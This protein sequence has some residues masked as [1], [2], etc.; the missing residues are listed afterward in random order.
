MAERNQAGST[1]ASVA[2]DEPT[3]TSSSPLTTLAES[4]HSQD[5]PDLPPHLRAS[6]TKVPVT[7]GIQASTYSSRPGSESE[8][9][10]SPSYFTRKPGSHE[11]PVSDGLPS[12]SPSEMS[13]PTNLVKGATSHHEVLRRMSIST[14]GRRESIED[15]RAAAP[16]L[17]LSG[18]IISVTSTT[19]HSLKYHKSGNWELGY[20]RGQSA[21]FDSFSYLSSDDTPWNHS[22][23]AWTGEIESS[24]QS[25]SA[26][27]VLSD[28][29]S[30]IPALSHLSAP[31]PLDGEAPPTPPEVDGLWIPREHQLRLE[32]LL[33]HNKRI[34]TIPVWLTDDNEAGDEGITLNDQA[35][36]KRY[37]EHTIYPLFH[38]KQHEPNDGRAERVEWADYFRANLKFANKIIEVY[39]PGDIVVIHDYYLL[40][41]PTMLR[42][43]MPNMYISFFLHCPFPSSEFL[44]CLPR[45]KEVLEGMLGANLVGFQ[46]YSY[47]RHFASC[48]TRI[49]DFPSDSLGVDAYGSRVEVGVFPIGIDVAKVEH[50]AWTKEVSEMYDAL[51]LLYKDK[52][53]IVGRDR[54]DSVRGVAQKLMAFERFLEL[55]PDW[56][57]KVVLI[58]VTSPGSIE[59]EGEEVENKVAS[60]VN[61][62]VMRINGTY[63]SLGFSP[64]QHYPQ[65]LSPE[66]YF[67][68]LRAADI[69]LITSVRDGMNTTSLEYVVCQRDTHG[70]LIL[71]EFSGTAGSLRDAIHIN[72][73][74]LTDVAHQIHNALTMSSERRS[75]MHNGLYRHVTTQ[76]VQS[77]IAKFLRKLVSTLASTK[78]NNV[79][80]L[81]DRTL[82]LKHYREATKRLLMFDYDGTLTP[83]V[84]DPQ[85]A[86]PSERVIHTLK[87]LA[88][89]HRNAVWIISGRDQ[90]FLQHHLGH[91]SELGFSAEHGSFIRHPGQSNWENLA[92]KLD[93]SWQADVMNLFQKYTDRVPGS[94]IERKR[95]AL[96]W[97]YRQADPEQ[98][99]HSS[100]GLHKELEATVAK[101]WDVD[102]MKGKANLEVRPTFINKGEIAKRLANDYNS[103]IAQLAGSGQPGSPNGLVEEGKLEFV[104]CMGDDFTDE[105]MFRAL[106]GLS[107]TQIEADRVFT[108][109]IGASTKVTLAK[110]HMLEPG[111]VIE[112]V[113]L[114]AGAGSSGE[115]GEQLSQVNL[116][117]VAGLE[118]HVP[119]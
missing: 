93:M 25:V 104:L 1:P 70:P 119:Q 3:L 86:I 7:P 6:V 106:N 98:G 46:S 107:G 40:L 91:I 112:A 23:V 31:I 12:Q 8:K 73:W 45:R 80:P 76:N 58:Q 60:R 78:N 97:H 27:N 69:G 57:E 103:D 117:T 77:W 54:L 16:D 96:T 4:A 79:T 51:K 11:N 5:S 19:P 66:E 32:N 100:Q 85:A 114:L 56:R 21:L 72:P 95:C 47:S 116:A 89:D 15:I 101:K 48:C 39:K 111:D 42:Q 18:N 81:L 36:W 53:I 61:E 2:A 35:R 75:A 17:A 33:A 84:R 115:V 65:Y 10:A 49:L 13:S 28:T 37:A 109:T 43:R 83:I 74:D 50:I 64:V 99:I 62:L 68:L 88:A 22:V 44:R 52:Q 71:S 20:R 30:K 9:A 29:T 118:G 82:M 63:G 108:V 113:A 87:A 102:V 94:F 38:Y 24:T 26:S 67:A 41:L 34:K 92:E 14:K 59:E 90:D 105:D 55:Y 110:W